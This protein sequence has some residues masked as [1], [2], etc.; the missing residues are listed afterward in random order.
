MSHDFG[1]LGGQNPRFPI[2]KPDRI[3]YGK[4]PSNQWKG[5]IR[6]SSLGCLFEQMY[7]FWWI[8]HV[9]KGDI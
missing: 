9:G 2:M 1:C 4:A 6:R 8:L 7:E 5:K 3:R